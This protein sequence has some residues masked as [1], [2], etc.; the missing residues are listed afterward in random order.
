ML[1]S[2]LTTIAV[3]LP[4][5]LFAGLAKKLFVPLALTV[6]VAMVASYFVS[7]AVTPGRVPLHARP[8]RAG[9]AR[10]SASSA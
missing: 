3:L 8:R 6:A 2:T 1:A 9:P 7:V 5:L 10:A 4:V